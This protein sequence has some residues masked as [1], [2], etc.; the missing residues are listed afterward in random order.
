MSQSGLQA[1]SN[2]S[3][4]FLSEQHD[5]SDFL[6]GVAIA[7]IMDGSRTFLIEIQALCL[8]DCPVPASASGLFTG[9]QANRANLIKCV[10]IKQAGLHL[11]EN[12]VFLNVVSG[13]TMT[14]TA[15][16]LAIAAAICSSFLEFPIPKGIA[17]IGEIGL[18]G[19]LRM[20]PRIEKRVYTVAKLGY[21]ICIVPK[22]A[23]KVLETEGLEKM[24]VVGC[25]NL[26]EV[27]NTVFTRDN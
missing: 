17:F 24:R 3:E 27:I 9:I 22:Q 6:A 2:A 10:L 26:K 1:V 11:Q 4:I 7:V 25:N 13:L 20:V 8:S 18:G 21:R 19:E 23:E 14:E 12:A 15:G 16:D 5:D